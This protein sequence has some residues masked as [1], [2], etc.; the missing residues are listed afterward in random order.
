M[1]PRKNPQVVVDLHRMLHSLTER[2]AKLLASLERWDPLHRPILEIDT[3][4]RTVAPLVRSHSQPVTRCGRS[5]V[6]R[7]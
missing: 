2:T 1:D 4:L 7:K 5:K 6:S 3:E